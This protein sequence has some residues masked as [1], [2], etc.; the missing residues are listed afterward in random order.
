M[1]RPGVNRGHCGERPATNSLS[2]GMGDIVF[3]LTTCFAANILT[4]AFDIQHL[5]VMN[6]NI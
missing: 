5:K 4:L 2:H 1:D 3:K 6:F